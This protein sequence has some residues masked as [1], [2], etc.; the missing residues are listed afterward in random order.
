MF[1]NA[2][3]RLAASVTFLLLA[4]VAVAPTAAAATEPASAEA[5]CPLL[6]LW[7]AG[8][9]WAAVALNLV[10]T[11][12]VIVTCDV[13]GGPACGFNVCEETNICTEQD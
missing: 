7:D 5:I 8:L 9:C 11:V 10:G 3:R 13:I 6:P 2:P 12:Y 1:S 4:A